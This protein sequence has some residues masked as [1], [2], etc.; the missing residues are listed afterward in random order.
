[1]AEKYLDIPKMLDAEGKRRLC[2]C[3]WP[4]S[5]PGRVGP[6]SPRWE[7]KRSGLWDLIWGAWGSPAAGDS[8]VP[9]GLE[10][11]LAGAEKGFEAISASAA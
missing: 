2:L 4:F 5:H 3:L 8:S 6:G 1:M 9:W 7:E 10:G 11:R